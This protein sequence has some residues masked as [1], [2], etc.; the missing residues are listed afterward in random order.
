MVARLLCR[1]V[2]LFFLLAGIACCLTGAVLTVGLFKHG[3]NGEAFFLTV[4][5]FVLG[6]L[7]IHSS[8]RSCKCR[9]TGPR[10]AGAP[11]RRARSRRCERRRRLHL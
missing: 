1:L 10:P 6:P 11:G 9:P 4:W 7:L 8:G 3:A 5:A 2:S